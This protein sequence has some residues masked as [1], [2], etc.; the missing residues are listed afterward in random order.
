MPLT[1][2]DILV[3]QLDKELLKRLKSPPL[4]DGG[5]FAPKKAFSLVKAIPSP[6][7]A[8]AATSGTVAR[9]GLL[10]VDHSADL[11]W[12]QHRPGVASCNAGGAAH[13]N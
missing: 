5:G 6:V 2:N 8:E 7:N 11:M 9:V 3:A 1:T 13:A 12:L 10:M 4:I